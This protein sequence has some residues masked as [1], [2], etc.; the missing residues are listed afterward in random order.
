[1]PP[2]Q[3]RAPLT[4]SFSSVFALA[5]LTCFP[6]A[7]WQT[8]PLP[9]V[10]AC[11]TRRGLRQPPITKQFRG[12]KIVISVNSSADSSIGRLSRVSIRPAARFQT[13]LISRFSST[14]TGAPRLA[15]ASM[16]PRHLR[17]GRYVPRGDG[18]QPWQQRPQRRVDDPGKASSSIGSRR[19][20]RSAPDGTCRRP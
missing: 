1:M 11:R 2:H 7:S 18:I 19:G 13:W 10:P 4:K 9:S 12:F 15:T 6:S 17:G 14:G 5:K 16:A 20:A 3:A 8:E